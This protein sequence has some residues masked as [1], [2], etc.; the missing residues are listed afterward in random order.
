LVEG[1]GVAEGAQAACELLVEQ[2]GPLGLACL[3]GQWQGPAEQ[4]PGPGVVAGRVGDLGAARQHRHQVRPGPLLGVRHPVPH[5]AVGWAHAMCTPYQ[6]T[7]QVASHWGGT[8]NGTIVH[9]PGGIQARGE[10]RHQFH[11]VIDVAPTI[12]EAAR[13][14][15]P[16]QVNGI[17]Q[18]PME[19][20][21]MRYSFADA[22]D[23]HQTQYFEIFGN[24]GIYHQGWSAITPCC[25]RQELA[26]LQSP[27]G[28][29]NQASRIGV[30]QV[31]RV[32]APGW[33]GGEAG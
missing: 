2:A 6:W 16:A 33:P 22:A 14:P 20:V 10:Q 21:S 31:A 29:N 28:R 17:T 8:R 12:L 5:Y 27:S 11:R 19:G 30:A 24:R 18:K 23:R 32:S 13:L 1:F 7:K 9:W 3:V 25:R 26:R 4:L 15:E